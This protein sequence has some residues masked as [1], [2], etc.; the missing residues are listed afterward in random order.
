MTTERR[1]WRKASA[2]SDNGQCVEVAHTGD[3]V[4]DSKNATG[5]VLEV[6]R[7]SLGALLAAV[8]DGRLG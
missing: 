7:A 6:P 8:K 1:R 5:P 2:S 4:R 3:A